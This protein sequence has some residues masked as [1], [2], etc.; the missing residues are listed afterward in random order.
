MGWVAM[1]ER[2]RARVEAL[3]RV[4]DGSMSLAS[5]AAVVMG[6]GRRQAQR[7]LRRFRT[8]GAAAVRHRAR[9]AVRPAV[10]RRRAGLRPGRPCASSL[11]TSARRSRPRSSPSATGSR[12]RARRLARLDGGG[13][14]V[15][16][17]GA[18]PPP[19]P[20]P[21]LH[22]PHLHR[23][24][25]GELVRT[26]GSEH[27]WFEDRGPPC[28]LLVFIDDA[29]STLM[30][31]RFVP[32]ESTF[33]YFEAL[34]GYL[35]AHGRPVA[36]YSD[37]NSVFRVARR[38]AKSGHGMTEVSAA[39]SPSGRSRSGGANSRPGRRAASRGPT[40]PCRTGS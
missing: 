34:E 15:A 19:A 31:M 2:E 32:S 3:S 12:S 7:R 35:K 16:A 27:R 30:Q 18:T 13:R 1:S 37:K 22:G 4:L 23:E 20:A 29:T 11:P 6:V 36:F 38:D 21:R 28:T 14:S 26:C 17:P 5:A 39:R 8:E 10:P 33:A 25:L 9:A 40:A 24:R